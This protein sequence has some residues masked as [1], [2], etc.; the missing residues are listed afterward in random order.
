MNCSQVEEFLDGLLI[1]GDGARSELADVLVHIET[2]QACARDYENA[3]ETFAAL[4]LSHL[5]HAPDELKQQIMSQVTSANAAHVFQP[6]QRI[7]FP[8]RFGNRVGL[9][10]DSASFRR[11]SRL[12]VAFASVVMLIL[13]FVMHLNGQQSALANS[14]SRLKKIMDVSAGLHQATSMDCTVK[15]SDP[16]GRKSEYRLRWGAAGVTRVDVDPADGEEQTLW[17][18]RATVPLDPV[19]EP[20]ME[21]LTPS[22]LAQHIEEIYGLMQAGGGNGVGRD[23]FLLAGRENQRA[24][25]IV[26]DAGTYLPKTL[27]KYLPDS[28]QAGEER[29]CLM[30][31]RFLWN[32]P[33]SQELF[34]PGFDDARERGKR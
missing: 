18:S 31:V 22:M 25:E 21:F 8:A 32:Q 3:K 29:L 13:G 24:V 30:E 14:I 15:I 19:W 12:A 11:L 1:I 34:I 23:E 28:P 9:P 27:K 20:A 7:L 33:I 6:A 2:C 5:V 17:I 16:Q 4:H 26:I 10:A